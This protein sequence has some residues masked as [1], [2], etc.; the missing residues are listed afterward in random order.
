MFEGVVSSGNSPRFNLP[1]RSAMRS[2]NSSMAPMIVVRVVSLLLFVCVVCTIIFKYD[3]K[4]LMAFLRCE[5][6]GW[7]LRVQR[8]AN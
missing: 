3:G 1:S 5:P 2:S 8:L 6:S 7:W 4:F